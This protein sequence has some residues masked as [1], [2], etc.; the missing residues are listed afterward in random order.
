MISQEKLKELLDY[1]P[2]TGIFIWKVRKAIQIRIGDEAG[3]PD[4]YGYTRINLDKRQYMAHRLVWLYV[5]G[6]WPTGQIDHVNR[7]KNDNRLNNLR[8][9][10]GSQ[11]QANKNLSSNNTSGLRGVSWHKA[12]QKWRATLKR[13][14]TQKHIGFFDCKE[15]AY[16]V[17]SEYAESYF[18]DFWSWG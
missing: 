7:I 10:T 12:S 5:Y 14:G 17:Y 2:D 6:E 1:N 3:R 9:A 11:N 13:K 18:G 16:F 4:K 15:I 8:L